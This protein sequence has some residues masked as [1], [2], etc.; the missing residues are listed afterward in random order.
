[1]AVSV[2]SS[3]PVRCPALRPR[4]G[5]ARGARV[6]L[7][8]LVLGALLFVAPWPGRSFAADACGPTASAGPAGA[9]ERGNA[10]TAVGRPADALEAFEQSERDAL[11]R[12]DEALAALASA[13]AAR[14]AAELGRP[15]E[16]RKRLDALLDRTARLEDAS[17]RARLRLH[18]ARTLR[19]LGEPR[20]AATVL[21]EA[22]E[23]AR[24]A[25]AW[26][27][28]SYALGGLGELYEE[29]GRSDDALSLT[30][31]A[32][33][34]AQ[35]S[36]APDAVY[37]WQWQLGRIHAAA[38]RRDAALA[39]YR[40]SVATLR[41]VPELGHTGTEPVYEGL[42]ELLLARSA[43]SEPPERQRLLA[44]IRNA[45]EDL[46]TSELRDYFRDPCL[47]ARRKAAPDTIPGT[48]VV[49]PVPLEDRLVLIASLDGVLTSH[50]VDVGRTALEAEVREFRRR[51]EDRT[52]RAYRRNADQLY[53]WLIAPL[54]TTLAGDGVQT[55][56]FVPRGLLHM[57]PLAAL[58]DRE[59]G[60]FLI[61][62]VPLAITP[63]LTLT[64]PR[65]ID[66]ESV[67]LL[68]A[69]VSEAVQGFAPLD[70]VE[71]ELDAVFEV[72]P[73]ERLLNQ[74]FVAAS[75]ERELEGRPFGI[76]HV[77]SHGEFSSD[78]AESF[79]LTYDGRISM[80]RLAELV[81]RTRFRT[82]GLE[83]LT[84]SACET[85]TG[86][87]RAALGLAGVALQAGARSALATLWAVNDQVSA[88]LMIE[89]YRQL[90]DSKKSRAE[91][92]RQAQ[93]RVLKQRDY[94]H[95]AY[96]APYLLVSSWL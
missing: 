79:V 83:L 30:E 21:G 36:A 72:F 76:V 92:L 51:L 74:G 66:R 49:Y 42:V 95:P 90:S 44:E 53:E 2:R 71:V 78:A 29:G 68:A 16:A 57:I 94:R 47:D 35:R 48:L 23:D 88:E 96:W 15:E 41:D 34:S 7:R 9:L 5:G 32:L 80:D 55:L 85:A 17:L 31:R 3:E 50:A 58:H 69:G 39:A 4:A 13:S 8:L 27:L 38:G 10:S 91:A 28:H 87:G 46:N 19:D 1:M 22:I 70:F 6:R 65:A 73:G 20:R 33:F 63:G 14:S 93:L 75:F 45:L 86:D 12:G 37:R 56:V 84:L 52:T 81:R 60:R 54:E 25:K 26:R 11:E 43:E 82:R 18:A 89:F 40:A 67:Q 77:A 24:A 61:E 62:K 64:E 59:S